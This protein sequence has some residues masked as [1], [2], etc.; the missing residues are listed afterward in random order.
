MKD[1]I[2]RVEKRTLRYWFI[3]G[4]AEIFFGVVC[5]LLGFYFYLQIAL[6]EESLL[7]NLLTSGFLL[8][9]LALAWVG[10]RFISIAKNRLTYPRT[11]YVS[12]RREVRNKRLALAVAIGMSVSVVTVIIGQ[13]SVNWMPIIA[14][15]ITAFVWLLTAY[16]T[17]LLRF[18]IL[19]GVSLLIGIGLGI[20]NIGDIRGISL[21]FL[22]IG[23]PTLLSGGIT[24]WR[25][26][27]STEPAE[28]DIEES[29][30]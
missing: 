15:F 18:Y 1:E 29:G 17:D 12:Y 13:T 28:M 30:E 25:Y 11:G 27:R 24:L 23:L 10:R 7:N 4:L 20:N 2:D 9:I 14:G 19:S 3:D 8:F 16:R 26:L 6:P 21:F 5:F 22:A